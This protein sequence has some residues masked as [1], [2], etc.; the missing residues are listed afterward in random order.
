MSAAD[1][2]ARLLAASLRAPSHAGSPNHALHVGMHKLETQSPQ[3]DLTLKIERI[4]SSLRVAESA[5]LASTTLGPVKE[6]P[7][8]RPAG[9]QTSH[10]L[11]GLRGRHSSIQELA[12]DKKV[13]KEQQ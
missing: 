5:A 13:G 10:S 11:T 9:F 3:A 2:G 8:L 4:K 12:R 7:V 1:P 6:R